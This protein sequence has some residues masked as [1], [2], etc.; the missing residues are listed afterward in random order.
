V[1]LHCRSLSVLYGTVRHAVCPVL[2]LVP[3]TCGQ[4]LVQKG[5][6]KEAFVA[7]GTVVRVLLGV[8]GDDVVAQ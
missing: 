3:V 6:H 2:S 8:D 5:R 7:V 4:V 1:C